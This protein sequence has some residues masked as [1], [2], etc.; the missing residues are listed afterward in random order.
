M[1]KW[2]LISFSLLIF[3]STALFAQTSSTSSSSSSSSGTS[4]HGST[5]PKQTVPDTYYNDA[6]WPN[7][8]KRTYQ[9]NR[10][11]FTKRKAQSFKTG[12]P[13]AIKTPKTSTT[14]TTSTSSSSTGNK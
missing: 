9:N 5:P 14:P 4:K 8:Q 13:N 10:K 2:L 6:S 3:S 11:E 1:T 12:N 7:V